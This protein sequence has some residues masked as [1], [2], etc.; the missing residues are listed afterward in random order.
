MRPR[1]DTPGV[2][3]GRTDEE[4]FQRT[5]NALEII[6]VHADEQKRWV[7]SPL[8]SLSSPVCTPHPLPRRWGIPAP[9]MWQLLA[10]VLVL[11]EVKFE[12][13]GGDATAEGGKPAVTITAKPY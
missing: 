2:I 7:A 8:A 5:R 3:E 12:R 4:A 10:A 1:S 11:G 13:R 6:G 9:S